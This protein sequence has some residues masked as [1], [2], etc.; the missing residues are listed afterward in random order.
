VAAVEGESRRHSEGND[1]G[2]HRGQLG[3]QDLR[4]DE[5]DLTAIDGIERKDRHVEYDDAPWNR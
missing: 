2:P 1:G 4:L 3:C 5:E